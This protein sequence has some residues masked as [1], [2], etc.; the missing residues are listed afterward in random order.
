MAE[1]IKKKKKRSLAYI[2]IIGGC[3][4]LALTFF[5]ICQF[6]KAKC[7]ASDTMYASCSM[8]LANLKAKDVSGLDEET[9]AQHNE[10]IHYWE[11]TTKGFEKICKDN[12]AAYIGT[13]VPAYAFSMATLVA[14]GLVLKDAEK[15]KEKEEKEVA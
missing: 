1:K 3:A 6:E 12:R 13:A 8:S 9:L 4:A 11:V 2:A 7:R 15:V 14:F 5:T 10:L